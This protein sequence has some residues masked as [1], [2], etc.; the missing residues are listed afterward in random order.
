MKYIFY[1]FII[2]FFSILEAAPVKKLAGISNLYLSSIKL[3]AISE[4]SSDKVIYPDIGFVGEGFMAALLSNFHQNNP[5]V[6]LKHGHFIDN[7]SNYR[8]KLIYSP[9]WVYFENNLDLS[10]LTASDKKEMAKTVGT[11]YQIEL[12]LYTSL[13]EQKISGKYIIYFENKKIYSRHIQFTSTYIIKDKD[14]P[15][16]TEYDDDIDHF[17]DAL[18]HRGEIIKIYSELGGELGKQLRSLFIPKDKVV[19][20]K[21][22]K[23]KKRPKRTKRKLKFWDVIKPQY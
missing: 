10:Q 16:I 1:F 17:K 8:K 14:S 5:K 6:R 18:D 4:K 21:K 7:I 15:Y 22:T 9:D 2:A 13:W 12:D 19:K 11:S 20:V 3:N 23:K